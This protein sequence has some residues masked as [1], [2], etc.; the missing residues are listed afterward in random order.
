MPDINQ[1]AFKVIDQSSSGDSI[2]KQ[3]FQSDYDFNYRVFP[4]DLA[5]DYNGHYM[6]ININVK[7]KH[8]G[9]LNEGRSKLTSELNGRILQNETSKV[10]NLRFNPGINR[11][12]GTVPRSDVN[13]LNPAFGLS[14]NTRRIAESI[15]LHMP[16]PV[17]FNSSHIFEEVSMTHL[18]AQVG[19]LGVQAIGA[20][21][22]TA[23]GS[24][25]GGLVAGA[26]GG[27]LFNA[28]GSQA[29][30]ISS[31]MGSPINPRVEVLF[32][33][34]PQRQFT[35]ELLM[36]PKNEKESLAMKKIIQTLRYHA[37]AELDN[38][39]ALTIPGDNGSIGIPLFI[40]PSE[41]DITF[42]NKGVENENMPR[43][44]TCVME[45]I[46][47]DYAPTG[48][49]STFRNGHPVTARLSMAFRET[50]ILH[51]ERVLQG[52]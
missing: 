21:I 4:E 31:I 37:A 30:R 52:F 49:Y 24:V 38:S 14:R 46:E 11:F 20:A 23:F 6:V 35:M 34:T 26:V 18:A 25:A 39:F 33:H 1:N 16:S 32:A 10:D 13:I 50:E 5:S 27:S 3:L 41:F 28:I 36:A 7:T 44:N 47:V 40:P 19:K 2:G 9:N 51:K 45:R 29:G 22:G 43:I 48:I 17:I 42:F 12:G 15:A 8:S